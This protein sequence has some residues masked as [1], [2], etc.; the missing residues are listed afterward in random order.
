VAA[1]RGGFTFAGDNFF[2]WGLSDAR[3]ADPASPSGWTVPWTILEPTPLP[4][5]TVVT[6]LANNSFTM[7]LSGGTTPGA[8][9][10][11]AAFG[12][13]TRVYQVDRSNG[14]VSISSIDIT[15]ASGL[16]TLT[17]GLAAG[18]QVKVYGTPQ[19]DGTYKAHVLMYFTNTGGVA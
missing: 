17:S 1:P 18:T 10:M 11:S 12:S 8:V 9:D 19:M 14:I 4:R 15:A 5:A 3:W 7:T 2:A 13:A 16:S 6:G